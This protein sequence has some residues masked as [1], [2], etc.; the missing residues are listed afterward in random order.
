METYF[1]R[2]PQIRELTDL[3]LTKAIVYMIR[4]LKDQNNAIK[5]I[6]LQK[7]LI[8]EEGHLAGL[9]ESYLRLL[10]ELDRRIEIKPITHQTKS[11][12]ETA[13]AFQ[14]EF[15]KL[16]NIRTIRAIRRRIVSHLDLIPGGTLMHMIFPHSPNRLFSREKASEVVAR[17]KERARKR[18]GPR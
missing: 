8:A 15:S 9:A 5:R 1:V 11:T 16:L 14:E 6:G 18:R 7:Y 10:H 3:K 4:R 2:Q 17:R 13:M 12:K